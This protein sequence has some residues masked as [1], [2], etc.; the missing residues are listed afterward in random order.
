MPRRHV[1]HANASVACVR[2][3]AHERG[4]HQYNLQENRTIERGS[5]KEL[6]TAADHTAHH[7]EKHLRPAP[8][9][10]AAAERAQRRTM[11]SVQE[12]RQSTSATSCSWRRAEVIS[13]VM[14][15]ARVL[16]IKAL[17]SKANFR[18]ACRVVLSGTIAP[19]VRRRFVYAIRCANLLVEYSR[20]RDTAKAAC[21]LER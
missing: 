16:S 6:V 2:R 20:H 17:A 15:A 5:E 3:M 13:T 11:N 1:W 14:A 19:R 10:T 4:I 9:G 12:A 7:H 18:C 21:S 8:S